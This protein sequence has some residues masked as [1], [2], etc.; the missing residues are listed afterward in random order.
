MALSACHCRADPHRPHDQPFAA[1]SRAHTGYTLVQKRGGEF[2]FPGEPG[3]GD[4]SSLRSGRTSLDPPEGVRGMRPFMRAIAARASHAARR[5]ALSFAAPTARAQ[6]LALRSLRTGAGGRPDVGVP[7]LV[8]GDRTRHPMVLGTTPRPRVIRATRTNPSTA[9]RAKTSYL[10]LDARFARGT[11]STS[12]GRPGRGVQNGEQ[13]GGGEPESSASPST[14]EFGVS[15][16]LR[17]G[18]A[19]GVPRPLPDRGEARLWLPT[20]AS[21]TYVSEGKVRGSAEL[22]EGGAPIAWLVGG[23]RAGTEARK[24]SPTSPGDH[25]PWGAGVVHARR[26]PPGAARAEIYFFFFA[27]SP[28]AT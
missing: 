5:L 26:Q 20:G 9:R 14:G 12:N 4:Q 16:A 25:A 10:H 3:S 8:A 13:P 19:F 28:C 11:A 6:G 23:G 18:A 22:I 7:S 1:V 2:G 27:R 15:A 17:A 24:I 21:S